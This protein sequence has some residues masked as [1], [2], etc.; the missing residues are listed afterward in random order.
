MG[1]RNDADPIYSVHT[2]PNT[3]HVIERLASAY[4]HKTNYVP[5]ISN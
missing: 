3:M 2:M 1:G 4:Q 5:E